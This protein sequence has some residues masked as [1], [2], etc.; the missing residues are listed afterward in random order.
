MPE[1]IEL[2]DTHNAAQIFFDQAARPELRD[3]TRFMLPT[4]D[5]KDP[6]R[7]VTWG[8]TSTR[9][10]HLAAYLMER[11]V[12]DGS[13]VAVMAN[14]RLEWGIAGLA[15]MAARGTLVPIYPSLV[16]ESLAH[17]LRHS[18]AQVLIV[19]NA[20]LLDAVLRIWDQLDG[21]VQA[22]VLIDNAAVDAEALAGTEVITLARAEAEGEA[23][24]EGAPRLVLERAAQIR[25]DDVGCLIYTSG[26]TGMPKGVPLTHRNVGVNGSAWISLNEGLLHDGDVDLLWLP[27]SHV[28]GWGEFC[29][30]NQLEFLTY[31]SDPLK[32]LPHLQELRP[33][34]FMSVPAYWDKLAG[35]ALA[36]GNDRSAQLAELKRVTGG[37]LSFCLSGGAG[38]RRE[39]KDLF[40]EAGILIIEGYGL[41]ECSPTLTM[42]RH[43]DYDFDTVGKPFPGVELKLADDGEILARGENVFS[44][45]HKDPAA[46]A[47]IFDP[48]GWLKTGDLGRFNAAGFLQIIG[49]KKEI[50]VTAGGKN[51]PPENIELRFREEPL[52]AQLVVY[53]DGKKYLTA[54][55]DIDELAARQRLEREGLKAGDDAAVLRSHPRV[56]E[57]IQARVDAVNAELAR[58]E[59][60]KRFCVAPEALT[61]VGG[62]L[63]PSLKVKR[64]KVYERY[65]AELEALYR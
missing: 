59:T 7:P 47:E 36:A 40:L 21:A 2:D 3:R 65:E 38:L 62:L 33:H 8:E 58:Y 30:G 44:G 9:I 14:T 34:I 37:R 11:G 27:M 1:S 52:I 45:Y 15:Q 42:N 55:V 51:I 23:A 17:V 29:L 24:L 64:A 63:T 48:E 22:L 10:Q 13:K 16:G 18:D 41:T 6:W 35:A 4:G 26:T 50:L 61:V 43:D 46:T 57:L 5:A 28:F 25:L 32:A 31:F 19:E 20:A 49:R 56:L 53:G 54:L 60:I 39:V 12:D